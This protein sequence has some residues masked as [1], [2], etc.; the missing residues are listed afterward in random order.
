[1]RSYIFRFTLVLTAIIMAVRVYAAEGVEFTLNSPLLVKVG[2][3]FP[4]EFVL[5]AKPD[6]DSFVAP[7]FQGFDIAAGPRISSGQSIQIINGNMT[8]AVNHTTTYV[9]IAKS[10]G[11]FTIDPARVDV[12]KQRY[13]TKATAIEVVEESV[14]TQSQSQSQSQSRSNSREQSSTRIGEGDIMMRVELSRTS[15]YKGEALRATV[16]LYSRVDLVG[17]EG[18]KLPTFNGFWAQDITNNRMQTR[19]RE[20]LDGKVYDTHLIR[21]YLL[22]PQ[23][24]GELTIEPAQIDVVAQIVVQSN[25]RSIDPFFG[26]GHDFY[27]VNRHVESQPI[28]VD[29]K[30]LPAGAPA[31]FSGAVGQ[32]EIKL[33][34]LKSNIIAANEASKL[35]LKVE[36]K[37]NI[38]FVQA[39]KFELPNSIEQYTVRTQERINY[40]NDGAYGSKEFEYPFIPRVEGGYTIPVIEFSYYDPKQGAYVEL[41]TNQFSLN[42]TPDSSRRNEGVEVMRYTKEDIEILGRDIRFIKLGRTKLHEVDSSLVL[43]SLYFII[44]G[45]IIAIYAVL[46]VL[47]RRM[48]KESKNDALRR[49]KR[50]NKV[51]I[52]RFKRAKSYMDEANDK[53]FYAEIQ[54]GVW[55]YMSDKF[56]IPVADLTKESMREELIKRGVESDPIIGLMNLITHCEEAQYSPLSGGEMP[57]VY[58]VA[59]RLIS[60]VE[61]LVKQNKR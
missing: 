13:Q 42:V 45:A 58:G 28:K 27:N 49:G 4:I 47:L 54:H 29:V 35:L 56:Y 38:P 60:Q 52:Q 59:L 18:L 21:E 46:F 15:V 8:R 23:Q 51:V 6:G 33:D 43:S 25:R 10:A 11:Q 39:P 5:T 30:R 1:M 22:Y 20:T 24:S 31:S 7:N 61:S 14:A 34:P 2:E 16:K 37:G 19:G 40:D 50:A 3:P 53:A 36:G 48:I 32:F 17:S 41:K 57:D 44:I 26:G 12:D 55:G 9:L